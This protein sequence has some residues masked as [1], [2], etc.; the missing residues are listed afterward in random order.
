MFGKVYSQR[1][2]TTGTNFFSGI[3]R[4]EMHPIQAF[5]NFTWTF[6][7]KSMLIISLCC[8]FVIIPVSAFWAKRNLL[9]Y[10]RYKYIRFQCVHVRAHTHTH[11]NPSGKAIRP[12]FFLK[13]QGD[14]GEGRKSGAERKSK[15]FPCSTTNITG[16][17]TRK[18]P[19]VKL[20]SSKSVNNKSKR[21]IS[22]CLRG[23][24][25]WRPGQMYVPVIPPTSQ[26]LS[27]YRCAQLMHN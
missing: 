13:K 25:R 5:S 27:F 23:D 8:S 9:N 20:E 17:K 24:M 15:C 16:L 6:S 22:L 18:R 21:Q 2:I 4:S 14:G 19:D 26:T 7:Q 1:Q 3:L 11:T 12:H 10:K